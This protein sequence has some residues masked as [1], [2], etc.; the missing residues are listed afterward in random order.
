[1]FALEA[2]GPVRLTLFTHTQSQW[3]L[4]GK[5]EDKYKQM[6][7]TAVDGI[8]RRLVA[9]SKPSGLVFIGEI[10]GGDFEA[11]MDHLVCFVPGLLALG[12]L[13]GMPKAHLDLA[14]ALME[15]CYQMYAQMNAKLAPE[16][17]RFNMDDSAATDMDVRSHDAFNLLRPETVESLM[18]LYRV[19]RNETYRTYGRAIMNAFETHCKLPTGGYTSIDN[20]AMG[21]PTQFYRDEMESFFI[22][23]TLK[24]LF[25]LFSDAS[26]WPLDAIV[27]NTEAHP[28]PIASSP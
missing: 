5:R 13:H 12:Y 3:L 25:L 2:A 24:Y 9:K 8:M 20:V 21:P 28:F 14:E 10:V 23:E 26:V 16:I 27:F 17:V 1:M 18:V 22:A 6:Y 4:S 15:T 19:S 7:V 11:K